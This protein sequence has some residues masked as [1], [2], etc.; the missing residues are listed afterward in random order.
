MPETATPETAM[1]ETATPAAMGT[2]SHTPHD[3]PEG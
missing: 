2:A 1:P 3:L